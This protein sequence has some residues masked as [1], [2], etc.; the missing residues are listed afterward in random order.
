VERRRWRC[1]RW[2]WRRVEEHQK[3]TEKSKEQYK[4]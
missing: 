4:E 1:R 2:R 3:T